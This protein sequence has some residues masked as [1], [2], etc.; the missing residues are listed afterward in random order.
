MLTRKIIR[1]VL[2]GL[3]LIGVG[4]LA[5]RAAEPENKYYPRF[6]GECTWYAAERRAD[7]RFNTGHGYEWA[8]AS[9]AQGFVVDTTPRVGAIAVWA[10]GK[11]GGSNCCGHVA[12]VIRVTDATTF[13]V[14]EYNW[15]AYHEYDER[16]VTWEDGIEFIHGKSTP[17][18]LPD[19]LVAYTYSFNPNAP[20][21]G[22]R[23]Q[24]TVGASDNAG[25]RAVNAID[26]LIDGAM[27]GTVNAAS[28]TL[29]WD[30]G[31]AAAGTHRINFRA[32]LAGWSGNVNPREVNLVLQA[33]TTTNTS[34]RD[35][36]PDPW[37][38]SW[39][40]SERSRVIGAI[41]TIITSSE[42]GGSP[43]AGLKGFGQAILDYALAEIEPGRAGVNPAFALAMF[44]K[45]ANFATYGAAAGN[46]NPG[47][48]ICA[49][50]RPL[51]G[52]TSCNGRF[53]VY[54][55]MDTGIKA[56]YWLLQ[57]EYKPGSSRNCADITC[58]I[59]AYAPSAENNTRLYIDQVSAWTRDFQNRISNGA[60]PPPPPPPAAVPNPPTLRAPANRSNWFTLDEI[61]LS[62]NATAHATQYKVE[63]SGGPYATMIPC[64]W[65]SGT[66]CRIGAMREGQMQWRVKARN[67]SGQESNWSDPWTFSVQSETRIITVTPTATHT[68]QP[69]FAARP[70]LASPNN[71]TSLSAAI[72]VILI[73]NAATNATQYKVELWGGTYSRMTPCDWQNG[74]TCRI[75]T[76][77]PGT[78]QWRVKARNASGIES[79]WS[80][81]WSFTIQSDVTVTPT[82]TPIPASANRP[83]LSS[84]NNGASLA[85]NTEVTL[86]WNTATNATQYKVELWGGAYS[87][88]T[89]CNWQSG[90][91]CRIG[92]MWPG[93]MQ[94]HV[95]ARNA[96]G[97]ESDWSDT[98]SFT[99]QQAITPTPTR[100]NVP[101]AANRPA[102]SSPNN[103]ASMAQSTEV[104]LVW[105]TASNATHYKVELW[106]GPYSTMTPCNWQ[107]G[108]T[109]RIGTMW[110][111]TMQWR[112]RAH[113]ASGVES[114]WSDTWSFTIQQASTPTPTRTNVPS[115]PSPGRVVLTQ[116]LT[117]SPS[118]PT[119]GQSVNARFVAKNIGGAPVPFRFFGVK[120][121]HSSGATYDFHWLENFTL[122]PN[123]EF[124]Y[125]VNR[126]F[127]RTGNF[128]FTP[129]YSLTGSTW[130]DLTFSNGATSYVSINVR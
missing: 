28:G 108:T 49:G 20:T 73:W 113:N 3:T 95:K 54:P 63:L 48:I 25:H 111:G 32:R 2:L 117:V 75:G 33:P 129:N 34:P 8:G 84:P 35:S 110:P 14:A 76:M 92:T 82:R 51:Y 57:Y 97:I 26:V 123:Q 89:P 118:S 18:P 38:T 90:T 11:A 53:G 64:D 88:M 41:E 12:Y 4:W 46:K 31:G 1:S 126:T 37:D 36:G 87:T 15:D 81:T 102:L 96:S 107:S 66:S 5:A 70:S 6:W 7:L 78:M 65:Q 39:L 40:P 99:I 101:P 74:T 56:Y 27:L 23:V 67:A 86:I 79:D 71:G 98:W 120:G 125:D 109:C 68:P 10:Q 83:T 69:V 62:W 45:E 80:D 19:P 43:N 85:Q 127:D 17:P 130:A 105:N 104:T 128:T 72:E 106:G 42:T 91:T 124:T 103:G 16:D 22:T 13:R 119:R 52:A 112:I 9:R 55:S 116:G 122:Q 77:W 50:T 30:T 47:N 29:A 60:P 59:N 115:P 121:R 61:V 58:I 100:T 93:T 114:D 24:I 44:R 94:W 21:V